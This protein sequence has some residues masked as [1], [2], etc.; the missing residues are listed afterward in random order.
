MLLAVFFFLTTS[1][2]IDSLKALL[3]QRPQLPIV[4][5]LHSEYLHKQDF[6]S[7][8][9][10]LRLYETR[11]GANDRSALNLLIGDTYLFSGNI[12]SAREAYL[13]TV[14]RNPRSEHANNALEMLYLIETTSGDTV[15]LKRLGRALY[16][17]Q[18]QQYEAAQ[19]SLRLLL[20]TRAAP[21]AFYY[22]ARVYEEQDD[23]PLAIG[24]LRE[25]NEKYPDHTI[26]TAHLY[27]A[28][29]YM[30]SN[31]SKQAR[32]VLEEVVV[33]APHSIYAVRARE[34]LSALHP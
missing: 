23:V 32:E 19:D 34:M 30:R 26:H 29:L 28:E 22:L 6:D 24:T 18:T 10:L 33:S 11:L 20:K 13:Q 31:N 17:F 14:I 1:S 25:L 9:A 16:Y 21:Y 2:T 15:S 5:E 27:L 3:A 4:L 12:L 7:A 8:L